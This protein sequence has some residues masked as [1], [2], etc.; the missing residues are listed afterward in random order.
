M[1][2]TLYARRPWSAPIADGVVSASMRRTNTQCFCKLPPSSCRYSQNNLIMDELAKDLKFRLRLAEDS[3][4]ARVIMN[5]AWYIDRFQQLS[6][7]SNACGPRLDLPSNMSPGMLRSHLNA[8]LATSST[9]N[10]EFLFDITMKYMMS[11]R[12]LSAQSKVGELWSSAAKLWS[13]T[14]TGTC[15]LEK[16]QNLCTLLAF[17]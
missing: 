17:E 10:T 12:D 4:S 9:V 13:R 8:L 14:H 7:R 15:W 11:S 5:R 2:G 3:D 16:H 6:K 1:F